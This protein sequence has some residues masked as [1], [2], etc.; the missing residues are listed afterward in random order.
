MRVT[1]TREDVYGY[2]EPGGDERVTL[3][4]AVQALLALRQGGVQK[5]V[6]VGQHS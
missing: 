4:G 6:S 3:V 2:T 5:Q 1:W